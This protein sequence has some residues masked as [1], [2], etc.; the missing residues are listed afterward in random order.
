MNFTRGTPSELRGHGGYW[1]HPGGRES[2][3]STAFRVASTHP[4]SAPRHPRPPQCCCGPAERSF[5]L[6]P[7]SSWAGDSSRQGA[8]SA[9]PR[10]TQSTIEREIEGSALTTIELRSSADPSIRSARKR[11]TP[12]PRIPVSPYPRTTPPATAS[13]TP[14]RS[15]TASSARPRR[16][17]CADT[18]GRPARASG[19]SSPASRPP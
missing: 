17:A 8:P 15:R 6:A 14:P 10:E 12:F 4:R 18:P 11:R 3:L 13:A 9:P 1:E 16:S 7:C 19:C 2:T 5:R